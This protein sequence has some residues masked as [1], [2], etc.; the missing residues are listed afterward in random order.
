MGRRGDLPPICARLDPR[1]TA[2]R[3]AVLGV[4]AGIVLL[5]LTGSVKATWSFSAFTVL[6][7]Y[8]ITNWAALKLDDR[9][10]RYPRL[11]ALLGLASCLF[12][13][14]WVQPQ[15]WL[16]GVVLIAV[17]LMWH[18]WRRTRGSATTIEF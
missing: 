7:Y 6:V 9:Q 2:P 12:L 5:V 16:A 13:A 18:H 1:G 14:F 17:G 15:V 10:R 4:S 3:V 8:A 11:V